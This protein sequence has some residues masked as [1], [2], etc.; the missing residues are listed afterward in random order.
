MRFDKI[1]GAK[2]EDENV[3]H[4]CGPFI[5]TFWVGPTFM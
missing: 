2:L 3:L 1:K 4:G 5:E